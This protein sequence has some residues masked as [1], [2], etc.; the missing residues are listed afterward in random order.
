MLRTSGRVIMNVNDNSFPVYRP[1]VSSFAIVSFVAVRYKF[2]GDA[3]QKHVFT[4]L[5]LKSN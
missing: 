3:I 1:V 2:S 4:A 5:I